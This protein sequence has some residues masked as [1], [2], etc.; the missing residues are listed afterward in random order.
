MLSKFFIDRPIFATVLSVVITLTGGIALWFLPIAQYPRI[1][2]PSVNV[3]INYPGASAQVV[4][5]TVAAP[6][7]QQVTG[8]PGMLYMSSQM[9]NDG[10]YQLSVTFDVDVDLSTALV[11]VQNRVALAMPLLPTPVQNQGI[12]IRKKTPDNLCMI[13]FISAIDIT[14]NDGKTIRGVI[15]GDD[16]EQITLL[17]AEGE[18]HQIKKDDIRSTGK[19]IYDDLFL[20]NY[21]LINV[22]D[23]ILRVD[24]VSDLNIMGQRDYSIR[25]WLNPQQLASRNMTATDVALAIRQQNIQA[26]AGQIGSPPARAGQPFQLPI[27]TLGRLADAEQ[28]GNIIVKVGES[29][30]LRPRSGVKATSPAGATDGGTTT[31]DMTSG[32]ATGGT[33]GGANATGGANSGGGGTTGGG[34]DTGVIVGPSA[35]PRLKTNKTDK[36]LVSMASTAQGS[37]NPSVSIVRLRDVARVEMGALNYN[38]T[39]TFNGGPSVGLN[40][41]QLPGT[42]ALDVADRVRAKMK[43]LKKAF[44]AG[45][46]YTIAYDTTPF[47]RESISEVFSTLR[48]AVFLVALVVLFF[49]QDWRAMILPMIDVP[50]SLIGTFAVMAVMGYSLNNISLFG[51]VL[52]I[53]IVV[54]DAIVVLENIERQMAKGF[55]TRTATIKAMEEITGPILAITLVLCAV[56]IPCAFISG[57]TGRFFRQ[58]A[59][60]IAAS[61]IISAINALTMTPSRALLIFKTK[62]VSGESSQNAAYDPPLT[63]HHSPLTTHQHKKEALPWWIFGMIGFISLA[64]GPALIGGPLGLPS[65]ATDEEGPD[66]PTLQTWGMTVA[67]FTPGFLAGLTLGWLIIRPVNMVLG[68]FFRGFNN[69]FDRLTDV[70]GWMIGKG[71]RLSAI[72]V[73][74]YGGLL[75]FTYF[76]FRDSPRGFVPQ[77][78]MGRLIVSVQLPDSAGLDRTQLVIAQADKIIR[79]DPGIAASI[80]LSGVSFAEQATGSNFGSFFVILKPFAQRQ[81]RKLRAEAI[82]SRLRKE[83]AAQVNDARVVV[84]GSSPIPGVSSSGGFKVMVQD[85]GGL[86]LPTLQKQTE[87]LVEKLQGYYKLT[88]TSFAALRAPKIQ[89]HVL[90]KIASL[91]DQHFSAILELKDQLAESLSKNEMLLYESLILTQAKRPD[92]EYELTDESFAAFRASKVPEPTLEK[93]AGLRDQSY[94]ATQPFKAKLAELLDKKELQQAEPVILVNAKQSYG[95]TGVNSQFRSNTPQLK[96]D[97]DR[98]KVESLEVSLDDVNQTLQI[99]LGS[100]NVNRFNEYGR[101]WQVTLQADH[102]FR[103]RTED[104]NLLQVRNKKGQMVPLGTLVNVR[105]VTGPIFVRRYNLYTAAPITGALVPGISSGDVIKSVDEISQDTLPR[106]MKS[107]WTELM[108]M[109]IK[110]GNTTAIVFTLAVVCVFLALAALYESWTLPLAVILVVPL[111]VLC[112]V[113]GVLFRRDYLGQDASV[114]IFVQIG[115]VVLVGLA[116]K[117]A[118]LV[119]EFAKELHQNGRSVYDATLEASRLRLRPILMTSFAFI[120]GVL[121]LCVAAGAGAEMRRSLGTAVFSGM[122]GVTTFGIFLTPVFFYVIQRIGETSLFT[123]AAVQW[124]G[125]CVVGALLGAGIAYLLARLGILPIIPRFWMVTIGASTG[126]LAI[127]AVRGM[128]KGLSRRS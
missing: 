74:A 10:S 78:D 115:L 32:G 128:H 108:F 62:S 50:V 47:I 73:I 96:L 116:C 93:L 118:I 14:T 7:E 82:M 11:M 33:G 77:Q 61:T 31:S 85:R 65:M 125:S 104:I 6:I 105:E 42:N 70:Y 39:C 20:S 111:C 119:V 19:P 16:D 89:P 30:P 56:F 43:E 21:A 109:Q 27:D 22:K 2:P 84:L 114:D 63:T 4:A 45:L 52:A 123:G 101:F 44:P 3:S 12:T 112:S 64:W 126:V 76:I 72:V 48:D 121:P 83:F 35:A 91:K 17:D 86:G 36:A 51:L 58:F 102:D 13:N 57:I 59:L 15:K 95:L 24:G 53:G 34:A 5:D 46:D 117:N 87:N 110:E 90:E 94:E 80:G 54:D 113:L 68:S 66:L 29:Q 38:V 67:Y 75:F 55:D 40:V 37:L 71:L 41:Y 122:L 28:F 26:A 124:I 106:S 81:D 97:I 98:I 107:E 8:V 18:K 127:A 9:G 1:T 92:G 23:E 100:L 49:L 25:A 79:R 60:T 99:Y 120:L 69:V 88:D 103:S